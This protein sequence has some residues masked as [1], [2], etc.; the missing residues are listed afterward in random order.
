MYSASSKGIDASSSPPLPPLSPP[1]PFHA[2]VPRGSISRSIRDDGG[3]G[4]GGGGGCPETSRALV[5]LQKFPIV[6]RLFT[7]ATTIAP[8]ARSSVCSL[9]IRDAKRPTTERRRQ[10]QPRSVAKLDTI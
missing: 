9:A 6:Q 1:P 7:Y 4:G 2:S 10:P 3:G 5:N 8:L